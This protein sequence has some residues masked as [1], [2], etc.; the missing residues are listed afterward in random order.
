MQSAINKDKISTLNLI[1][2][3]ENENIS[4]KFWQ[5]NF[6]ND[7]NVVFYSLPFETETAA[8]SAFDKFVK[9]YGLFQ[10]KGKEPSE[11]NPQV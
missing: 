4:R 2:P 11:D 5:I 7:Q 1:D 6:V 10:I 9:D 8:N 3:V